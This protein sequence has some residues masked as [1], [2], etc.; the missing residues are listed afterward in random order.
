MAFKQVCA[1]LLV[2]VVCCTMAQPLSY[3]S[4]NQN[5][6]PFSNQGSL[7]YLNDNQVQSVYPIQSGP[8]NYI[9]N[10]GNPQIQ[11]IGAY[12]NVISS[13]GLIGNNGLGGSNIINNVNSGLSTV[14]YPGYAQTL[15]VNQIVSYP[16]V[17]SVVGGSQIQTISS[18][19][20][21][22]NSV[23]IV[24]N[25][26]LGSNIINNVNNGLLSPQYSTISQTLPVYNQ[27]VSYPSVQQVLPAQY[28]VQQPSVIG[29]SV[30]YPNNNQITNNQVAPVEVNISGN[31]GNF[32]RPCIL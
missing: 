2:A 22:I 11:T 23:G 27:V 15:P 25:N 3:L 4:D 12:P 13:V 16:N 21:A 18:Y 26:G 6:S 32:G 24:G 1:S 9:N 8:V 29:G 14:Q 5:G 7:T 10:I 30:G 31:P 28:A 17:Q 19:P 20:N